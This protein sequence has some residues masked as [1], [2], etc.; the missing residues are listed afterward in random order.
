MG[1]LRQDTT[2]IEVDAVITTVGSQLLSRGDFS[3]YSFSLGDDEVN[4][5]VIEQY[6]QTVG[7]EKIEKNTPIFEALRNTSLSLRSNL[8]SLSNPNQ[9]YLPVLSVNAGRLTSTNYINISRQSNV[10]VNLS[11]T[12]QQGAASIPSEIV[13][14]LYVVFVNRLFLAI[15]NQTPVNS[16]S[17]S[18]NPTLNTA[19][20]EIA[21][22]SPTADFTLRALSIPTATF[23]TYSAFSS[24]AYIRTYMRIIG[25]NSG[26]TKDVEVRITA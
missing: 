8:V 9:V 6:G 10:N 26:I 5:N 11:Q 15:N 7:K 20:Y 12:I 18:S 16:D 19:R 2:N 24:G 17:L 3:V 21:T 22:G 1:F 4:Y 23:N 14:N 13:D 25:R